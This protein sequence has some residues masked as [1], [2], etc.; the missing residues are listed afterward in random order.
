MKVAVL[1]D[2]EVQLDTLWNRE[3]NLLDWF[4]YYA[5][6]ALR[7]LGHDVEVIRFHYRLSETVEKLI[8]EAPN[9]IFNLMTPGRFGDMRDLAMVST[10][11]CM[12]FGYTGTGPMGLAL[13]RDKGLSKFIVQHAGVRVPNYFV[14]PL[15][16]IELPSEL[17]FPLIVK[18][19]SSG[20]GVG[21]TA[22]SL[23]FDRSS[24]K[25][26]IEFIHSSLRQPA[27]CEQYISGRE[28]TVGVDATQGIEVLPPFEWLFP[29]DPSV[30][31]F[32]TYTAKWD[33]EYRRRTGIYSVRP[34]LDPD[35]ATL[36]RRYS[37]TAFSQL[38][39]RDYASFDF[40]LQEGTN[41]LYFIEANANPGLW[42]DSGRFGLVPFHDF[43]ERIL[44][45][46][47]ERCRY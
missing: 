12:G 13:S 32:F 20:G 46:A 25:Q 14:A 11:D 44:I 39:L 34:E 9:A 40:R 28:I 7:E 15:E 19:L 26:Q 17:D 8:E 10:L 2:P 1:L 42:P 45:K 43:V 3:G 22:D 18:P 29:K 16:A 30:P 5:I 31:N 37:M 23:V 6:T 21:I 38:R 47:A 41:D 4:D 27:I 35:I 36:V 24:C 33:E